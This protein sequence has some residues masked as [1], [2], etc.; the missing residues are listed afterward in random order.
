MLTKEYPYYEC[1]NTAQIMKLVMDGILPQSLEGITLPSAKDFITKCLAADPA[2]RPCA[3]E[4]KKHEF[5]KKGLED[6]IEVKLGVPLE[7]K[8]RSSVQISDPGKVS[9]GPTASAPAAAAAKVQ[10]SNPPATNQSKPS[11]NQG[12]ASQQANP[13]V[14]SQPKSV[15]PVNQGQTSQSAANPNQPANK[16]ASMIQ[17]NNTNTVNVPLKSPMKN[18]QPTNTSQ[19]PVQTG[20]GNQVQTG[21]GQPMVTSTTNQHMSAQPPLQGA[22]LPTPNHYTQPPQPQQ[23]PYIQQPHQIHAPSQNQLQPQHMMPPQYNTQQPH[24]TQSQLMQHNQQDVPRSRSYEDEQQKARTSSSDSFDPST[25]GV[26]LQ[27]HNGNTTAQVNVMLMKGPT[28]NNDHIQQ[29]HM[30]NNHYGG[31]QAHQLRSHLAQQVELTPSTSS[32]G[33]FEALPQNGE[34]HYFTSSNLHHDHQ[35]FYATPVDDQHQSDA[36]QHQ[37]SGIMYDY[38][39]NPESTNEVNVDIELP[40]TGDLTIVSFP[41]DYLHDEPLVVATEMCEA[42]GVPEQVESIVN[43]LTDIRHNMNKESGA[44]D[45]QNNSCCEKDSSECECEPDRSEDD[46]KEKEALDA[47]IN[48]GTK[49][50]EGR[51][52]R[53]E[54]NLLHQEKMEEARR[55]KYLQELNETK[56]KD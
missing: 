41:Y 16:N 14:A 3:E 56:K 32:G 25:L 13:S 18:N 12:Q 17:Q 21:H 54:E 46:P 19:P 15:Q 55:N 53:M 47:A 28:T 42:F 20:Q 31:N 37:S 30:N 11:V 7:L 23:Q 51:L 52:K 39:T 24:L 44:E 1:S 35:Q 40:I 38:D 5:L 45:D 2:S 22:P 9:P 26:P 49:Y 6:D 36:L 8:R 43:I 50:D 29:Q 33:S 34:E 4:L 48:A 10:Q 27:M